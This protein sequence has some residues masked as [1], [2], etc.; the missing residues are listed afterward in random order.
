MVV[1]RVYITCE[2]GPT[3]NGGRSRSSDMG[4]GAWCLLSSVCGPSI[5]T[6]M[7]RVTS[8]VIREAEMA[9]PGRVLS[10]ITLASVGRTLLTPSTHA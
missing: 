4:W 9:I 10:G 5:I 2:S 1:A 3:S 8:S 6:L 7:C